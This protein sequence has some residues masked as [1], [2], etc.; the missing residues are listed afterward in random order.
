MSI[1]D[2][3]E[4]ASGFPRPEKYNS[5]YVN[6]YSIPKSFACGKREDREA[7]K[8]EQGKYASCS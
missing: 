1:D 6:Q 5:Y 3:N 7:R 2:D 4:R 8:K